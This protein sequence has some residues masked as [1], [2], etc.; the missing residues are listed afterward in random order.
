MKK[1]FMSYVKNFLPKAFNKKGPAHKI[2]YIILAD[3]SGL[4]YNKNA[5]ISFRINARDFLLR[6]EWTINPFSERTK[7]VGIWKK[8]VKEYTVDNRVS[9]QIELKRLIEKYKDD[10]S[11]K[12]I[13]IQ[14][15]WLSL[16]EIYHCI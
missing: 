7:K 4:T 16:D 6:S 8:Y 14:E 10:K 12:N 15:L 2:F 5:Q 3:H 9:A 13:H 1:I 11:I